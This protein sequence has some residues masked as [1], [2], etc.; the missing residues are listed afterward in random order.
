MSFAELANPAMRQARENE[1]FRQCL[2]QAKF[3][4]TERHHRKRS[5]VEL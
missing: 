3:E 2:E 4:Q 5:Q 1:Y